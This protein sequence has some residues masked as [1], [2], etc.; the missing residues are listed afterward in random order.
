MVR[1]MEKHRIGRV[2]PRREHLQ[3][4]H[5]SRSR[6]RLHQADDDTEGQGQA[7]VHEQSRVDLQ[8]ISEGE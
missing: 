4:K 5:P 8:K 2:G 7:A 6:P 1:V 3:Q